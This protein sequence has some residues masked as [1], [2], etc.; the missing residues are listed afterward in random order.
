MF[1]FFGMLV[2]AAAPAALAYGLR[3]ANASSVAVR[4]SYFYPPTKGK[5]TANVAEYGLASAEQ[6]FYQDGST[7]KTAEL[8][9]SEVGSFCY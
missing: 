9:V 5:G 7:N 1:N 8:C 3:A 4:C 2:A 6:L